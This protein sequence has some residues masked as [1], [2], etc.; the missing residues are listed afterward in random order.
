MRENNGL[1]EELKEL[2]INQSLDPDKKEAMKMT[3][4]KHAKK[5]GRSP[6]RK[7]WFIWLAATAVILISGVLLYPVVI[8][9][10]VLPA[11][12]NKPR[13]ESPS[14]KDEPGQGDPNDTGKTD[15]DIGTGPPDQE[16]YDEAEVEEL[17]TESYEIEI[18]GMT[19]PSTLHLF[20]MEP[21]G[22]HYEIDEILSDYVIEDFTVKH[23]LEDEDMGFV[24]LTMEKNASMED[25]ADD[26]EQ[27]YNEELEDVSV[28]E[29]PEMDTPYSGLSQ[30]GVDRSGDA[31]DSFVGYYVFQVE[32]DV[33]IIDYKY[34]VEA[35]DGISPRI[36]DM[37]ESIKIEE[38]A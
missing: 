11:D 13:S 35:A 2:K 4:Q 20:K 29:Q 27:Q 15:D 24:K 12:D 25:I 38:E 21:Y 26:F 36:Q 14:E 30:S 37:I 10:A 1:T 5:K 17:G 6:K 19:D 3:I 23:H 7:N 16:S 22:I 28:R 33:L 9:E 34:M 31:Y 8:N 32:D 18:E